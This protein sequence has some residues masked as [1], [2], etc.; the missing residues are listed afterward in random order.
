MPHESEGKNIEKRRRAQKS[1]E[2][3]RRHGRVFSS[4]CEPMP[5][6]PSRLRQ[7]I[8]PTWCKYTEGDGGV[9]RLRSSKSKVS[10]EQKARAAA[11]F[12]LR[13]SAL[14]YPSLSWGERQ[15]P[16]AICLRGN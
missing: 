15:P 14:F 9:V 5:P 7:G 13:S 11:L 1:V 12:L 8:F 4:M 16:D 6:T 3:R 2:E 10:T